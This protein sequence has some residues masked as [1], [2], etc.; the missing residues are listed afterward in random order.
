MRDIIELKGVGEK[1]KKG[2]L[3]LGIS[4]IEDLFTYFPRQ[5]DKMASP[6]LLSDVREGEVNTLCLKLIF[7]N[8]AKS[9]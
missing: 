5:Y 6:I 2:L 9:P 4:H 3:K 7:S 8:Y 1:S